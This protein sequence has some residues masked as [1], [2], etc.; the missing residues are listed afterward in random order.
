[1]TWTQNMIQVHQ[2]RND[3]SVFGSFVSTSYIP[4]VADQLQGSLASELKL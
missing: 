2:L 4:F 3:L 1:M